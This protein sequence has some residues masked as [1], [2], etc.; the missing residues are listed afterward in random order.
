MERMA[1]IRA[2]IMAVWVLITAVYAI[3]KDIKIDKLEKEIQAE[4]NRVIRLG[5]DLERLKRKY[6]NRMD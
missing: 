1:D 4:K 2:I 3:V 5:V 6:Y